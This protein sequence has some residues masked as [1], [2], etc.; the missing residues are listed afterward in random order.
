MAI[1]KVSGFMRGL[2]GRAGNAVYKLTKNGVELSDRPIVNNPDTPAQNVIRTAFSKVTKQ[3]KT[4]TAAEAAAW[5]AYAANYHLSNPVSGAKRTLSGFNWFV[6]LGTRYL[7]VNPASTAAP[8]T[9]PTA[10]FSGDSITITPSVVAG[11]IRFTAS[12]SNGSKTT[13]ALL[14]QKLSNG[15]TKPS[16]AYRTKAHFTFVTGTLQTTVNLTPGWYA[17]GYQYVNT[18][19][20]QETEAVYLGKIGPVAFAVADGGKGTSKKAA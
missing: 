13:T 20:G 12:G 7:T 6:A 14:V 9:P 18:D 5:N 11:G 3:W 19:T 8:T 4:L 1:V 15:N 10:D 17:V 16:S 2:S